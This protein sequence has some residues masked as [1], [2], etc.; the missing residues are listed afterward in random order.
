MKPNLRW[1]LLILLAVD[2]VLEVKNFSR[3]GFFFP[4]EMDW[5]RIDYQGASALR[6]FAYG[7]LLLWLAFKEK[8]L[9]AVS[10][11]YLL[12]KSAVFLSI[13]VQL[14]A[15]ATSWRTF[16]LLIKNDWWRLVSPFGVLLIFLSTTRVSF[17]NNSINFDPKES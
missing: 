11:I 13:L 2:F 16:G 5:A 6:A 9:S 15:S 7:S 3:V 10:V 1:L 4:K 17:K 8:V 14:F 12:V